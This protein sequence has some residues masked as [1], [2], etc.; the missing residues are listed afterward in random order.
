MSHSHDNDPNG[1]HP[2][3]AQRPDGAPE[4]A[5]SDR[6]AAG[7]P[8][9][10]PAPD[11][12]GREV[13]GATFADAGV[14]SGPRSSASS[15]DT[16]GE[17]TY[18]ATFADAG[19]ASGAPGS[20]SSP[21]QG[22]IGL[23]ASDLYE[24]VHLIGEGGMGTVSLARDRRLNR[25]LALKRL[26]AQF[27]SDARLIERF[28]TEAK[29]VAALTH[30]HIVQVFAMD[31]DFDGPYIAMEYVPG[32]A[33]EH[34]RPGWPPEAPNPPL[35]LEEMVNQDGVLEVPEVVRLGIKLCSA[36]GYA[37]KRGVIHR[38]IKPANI[39]IN[40]EKDPKLADFGLARQ[41]DSRAASMTLAGTQLL[42]LG[43]GA[44][45]QEID[46]S[47]VDERADIYSLGGTMWF[48]LT[49]ENP[50]H[51]R[52]SQVP[53][54]LRPILLRSLEKDR[55]KRYQTAKELE[56][57]LQRLD[58]R[59]ST[60]TGPVWTPAGQPVPGRC[61]ECG[62][63]HVVGRDG[64][65]DRKFCESCGS[66]LVEKCLACGSTNGVWARFCGS[67][68]AD[69]AAT[70]ASEREKLERKRADIETLR[71]DKQFTAAIVEL[72]GM[73]GLEHPRLLDLRQ[74]A[75]ETVVQVEVE[76]AQHQQLEIQELI[77]RLKEMAGGQK[78]PSHLAAFH[79][80]ATQTLEAVQHDFARAQSDRDRKTKEAETLTAAGAYAKAVALL[81]T[82]P[83]PLRTKP[84][85]EMLHDLQ[86]K[87]ETV[88]A[89]RTD[90]RNR[91]AAKQLWGE[92]LCALRESVD[93]LLE[94]QPNDEQILTLLNQ[95]EQRQRQEE[96]Q[97]WTSVYQRGT[98]DGFRTYLTRYPQGA[99]APMA[100]TLIS[101]R[102]REALL[103]NPRSEPLRNE[104][105]ATRTAEMEQEDVARA[106]LASLG[107]GAC[108]GVAGGVVLG[109]AIGAVTGAIGG[110]I[111]GLI[112][113]AIVGALCEQP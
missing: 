61:P 65:S 14:P 57:A 20:G 67:C 108:S 79:R 29:A 113:G 53:D 75:S 105:L 41:V 59:A 22:S 42:T 103:E 56:E 62:H 78:P 46:A 23:A 80:W 91:I 81:E 97:F 6:D 33:R 2:I 31:E 47:R 9:P 96:E 71:G 109:L 45:E 72:C 48:M 74:W 93:R 86:Q 10:P 100:K 73:T 88:V 82:V 107:I 94:L 28:R 36:V 32:P 8:Q 60:V 84:F 52:E 13:Y 4:A 63:Q 51:F 17:D 92:A 69:L 44:P 83:V 77:K 111:G 40:E 99:H 54:A 55:E 66:P 68:R 76:Q 37:H 95:V 58:P 11:A 110:A 50:R 35:D 43:Y 98:L 12:A 34:S 27:V 21:G 87:Q 38:D 26:G 3:P 106:R 64:G 18:G 89:L 15:A 19:V 7:P 101:P 85:L 49:G 112:G 70:C 30:Y 16:A 24:V 5:L 90:I 39:L 102:L 25:W 104:Y 1:P